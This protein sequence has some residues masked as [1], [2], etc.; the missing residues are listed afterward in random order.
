[1]MEHIPEICFTV[2]FIM[3]G[4][5]KCTEIIFDYRRSK[6]DVPPYPRGH[7]CFHCGEFSVYW[8]GDFSFEDYGEEGEGIIHECTCKHCGAR[9][10]YRIPCDL[11]EEE[12]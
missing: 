1:M 5:C 8:D 4:I 9:V 6:Q 10:T 7:E 12:E 11:E 3:I 2:I